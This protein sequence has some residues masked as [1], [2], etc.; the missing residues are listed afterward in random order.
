MKKRLS[1]AVAILLA[2]AI[3][4]CAADL[5][6]TMTH[7]LVSMPE[8]SNEADPS[9]AQISDTQVFTP[10]ITDP[11]ENA[12]RVTEIEKILLDWARLNLDDAAS[13]FGV[14]PAD[15][16]AR[17]AMLTSLKNFYPRIE[18]AILRARQDAAELQRMKDDTTPPELRMTD[19]PPFSLTY[20]DAFIG[21]LEEVHKKI[22]EVEENMKRAHSST[23]TI[24]R[25]KEDVE[26]EWRFARDTYQKNPTRENQWKLETASYE[27]EYAR[28]IQALDRV[29]WRQL[30]IL[31]ENYNLQLSRQTALQIY[32]CQNIDLTEEGYNKEINELNERIKKL[33]GRS[34]PVTRQ[35]RQAERLA[36]DAELKYAALAPDASEDEK[37]YVKSEL[38]YRLADRERCRLLVGQHQETIVMLALT[39]RLWELRYDLS[40]K[41]IDRTTIPETIKNMDRETADL[42]RNLADVQKRLLD[43]QAQQSGID[44]ALEE[45][46]TTQKSRS[47]MRKHRDVIQSTIESCLNFINSIRLTEAQ[48]RHFVSDLQAEFNTLNLVERLRRF[49]RVRVEKVLAT[50]LWASGGYT[51][52][53]QEFLIALAITVFGTWIARHLVHLLTWLLARRNKLDETRR[54]TFDRFIGNFAAIVVFV[55]ALYIVGIPLTA[56]AFLGGAAAISIG[57]G[58]QDIF[59]NLM[60]G[61]MLTL[62]RTFRIGDIIETSGI[63]GTVAD[64]GMRCT[65]IRTF[66][67]KEVIVPNADLTANQLTN[68]SLS[69]S[70]LRVQIDI[71]VEYGTE[72]KKVRE[73]LLKLLDANPKV[74]K[75]PAPWLC[76]VNFGDSAYEFK[77]YFWINQKIVGAARIGSEV[78]EDITIAFAKENIVIAFP[79]MDV[80]IYSGRLAVERALP[81]IPEPPEEAKPSLSIEPTK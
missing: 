47:V 77:L 15:A 8:G 10:S 71:G 76:F 68:W 55:I 78:R 53:L 7:G 14:T 65:I 6:S 28:C 70:L 27:L 60:G 13:R 34:T 32:I 48:E 39:K 66:D 24:A 31:L 63:C 23:D 11:E 69:D 56:F 58:A 44:K 17:I 21:T 59:K 40:R 26:A 9:G 35:L 72:V 45:S 19:K 18:N 29:N 46:T 79:H 1:I 5:V 36:G 20:H 38:D 74:L 49:W 81:E 51:V 52:R 73:T 2:L 37:H 42:Y 30:R 67:E 22:A 3:P 61:I 54:R 43:L 75:T 57:F 12:K 62:N 25:Q 16:A 80:N 50:E 64:V 41:A 4:A 33:E